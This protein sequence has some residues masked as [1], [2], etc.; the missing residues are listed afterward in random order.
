MFRCFF[1]FSVWYLIFT[2]FLCFNFSQINSSSIKAWNQVVNLLGLF[3]FI[4][5]K[6]VPLRGFE[7]SI[8][9]LEFLWWNQT[10]LCFLF[11]CIALCRRIKS[12]FIATNN[13]AHGTNKFL[14]VLLHKLNSFLLHIFDRLL[15][16]ILNKF[17]YTRLDNFESSR[18]VPLINL[19]KKNSG[20]N[21]PKFWTDLK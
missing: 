15:Q 11:D 13:R 20:L 9:H 18:F 19:I 21:H 8:S 17:C 7:I 16:T 4:Y 10:T 14:F 3:F 12:N 2:N 5:L 6:P 1:F